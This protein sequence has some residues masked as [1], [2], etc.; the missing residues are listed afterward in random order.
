MKVRD[1]LKLTDDTIDL[2]YKGSHVAEVKKSEQDW[3]QNNVGW[4]LDCT[5]T[6]I[7]IED[8]MLAI[9]TNE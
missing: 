5:I 8:D 6:S 1:I 2:Y 9:G 7:E 4:I 3:L